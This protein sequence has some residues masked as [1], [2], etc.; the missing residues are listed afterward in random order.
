MD[1][2]DLLRNIQS[3]F[4]FFFFFGVK[5]YYDGLFIS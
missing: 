3:F 2:K 4:F 5:P 1:F